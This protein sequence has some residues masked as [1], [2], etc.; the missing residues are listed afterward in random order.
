MSKLSCIQAPL[1]S[2]LGNNSS[3]LNP[4][5]DPNCTCPRSWQSSV[6]F[7]LVMA[8]KKCKWS[9]PLPWESSQLSLPYSLGLK[10]VSFVIL[11]RMSSWCCQIRHQVLYLRRKMVKPRY[12]NNHTNIP[13]WPLCWDP[14]DSKIR[15]NFSL[16][17]K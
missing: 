4:K 15:K 9:L 16:I 12:S 7:P 13:I 10:S 14:Q 17:F 2:F 8:R 3:E 11:M 1:G 6:N 5:L